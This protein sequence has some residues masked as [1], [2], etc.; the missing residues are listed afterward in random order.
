MQLHWG[1]C[2]SDPFGV[3]N[4]VQQGSILSPLVFAVYSDGLLE[5][6]IACG[7]SF[8]GAFPAHEQ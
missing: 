7:V 3:S 6:L 4:G 8:A 1:A 2:F 5:E